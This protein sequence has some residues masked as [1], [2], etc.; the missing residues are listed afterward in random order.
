MNS[1]VIDVEQRSQQWYQ[2]RLGRL[3]SSSAH[4]M[5]AIIKT[6]EA[7]AR[8]NLR[9]RLALERLTGRSHERD[10]QSQAMKDGVDREADAIAKYEEVTGRL[11]YSIGFVS[12]DDYMM[13]TSPD[14]FIGDVGSVSIKCPTPAVHLEYLKSGEIPL[15]YQRQNAHEL[16]VTGRK[17][18]DF[19][20]WNPDFTDLGL[21]W[22]LVHV[23]R[24]EDVI[25]DYQR[26]ALA[27]LDEVT[28][29]VQAVRTMANLRGVLEEA[30]A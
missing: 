29:E 8:R 22:K 19:F 24:D 7:A 18:I 4:D 25:R 21:D 1:T 26:R 12:C 17:W 6:G 5:L 2:A 9:V 20:S 16:L 15:E 10:F 27:F 28:T 13:G 3:T 30:T 14:G 23:E 11:V